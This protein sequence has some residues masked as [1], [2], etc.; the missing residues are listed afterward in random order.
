MVLIKVVF[1]DVK[2]GRVIGV[3]K[4]GV[5]TSLS[6]LVDD[7]GWVSLLFTSRK[8]STFIIIKF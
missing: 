8:G 5:E 6:N 4:L 3:P 2:P 7:F 1:R